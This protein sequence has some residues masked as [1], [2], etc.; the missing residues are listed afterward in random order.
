VVCLLL[1]LATALPMRA[2]EAG[3]LPPALV[4]KLLALQ[5]P[6][7]QW[8]NRE[9]QESPELIL[10][11]S[12]EL[13]KS[14]MPPQERAALR[15]VIVSIAQGEGI[16]P[17]W[18]NGRNI[19][20]ADEALG[21]LIA[22]GLYF[23][24]DIYVQDGREFPL[25]KPLLTRPFA[26]RP[27]LN[28]TPALA[29]GFL[30]KFPLELVTCPRQIKDCRDIQGMATILGTFGFLIAHEAGHFLLHHGEDKQRSLEE[31]L[32][33]DRK[34]WE[35]ISR[36]TPDPKEMSAE[37]ALPYRLAILG[38]PLLLL[39][40]QENPEGDREEIEARRSQLQELAGDDLDARIGEL[41]DPEQA[42]GRLREV[43]VTWTETPE[44]LYLNGELVSPAQVQGS[45]LK[46]YGSLKV[47]AVR[48]GR[49]AFQ[50]M[51]WVSRAPDT[52]QLTYQS[53]RSDVSQSEIDALR[54]DR[55]W[56]D[57][58]LAT[59]TPDLHPSSPKTGRLFYE[60]LD[61]LELGR[62]ID[63]SSP[64]LDPKGRRLAEIWR[65]RAEP[66]GRWR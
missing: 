62:L 28:L 54:R 37:E 45:P 9:M 26:A 51:K 40:W 21:D 4:K 13:L 43:R 55:R 16:A 11:L 59:A 32:K 29:G 17:A 2:Q 5:K 10:S 34:A 19:F 46:V 52:V 12:W 3:D 53:P 25:A 49:F 39:R 58:L 61:R 23:G 6:G 60:A 38:G 63:P 50:E 1:F 7:D 44:A 14:E 65:Q 56:F 8:S 22:L 27:I 42:L 30:W 15:D 47:F 24:H 18:I 66:L 41:V 36:F 35:I 31:E 20:I 33:A 57:L 48:Q 64:M